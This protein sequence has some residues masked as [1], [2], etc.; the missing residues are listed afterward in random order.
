MFILSL[1]YQMLDEEHTVFYMF[2][3]A[4][5]VLTGLTEQNGFVFCLKALELSFLAWHVKIT[6]KVWFIQPRPS[7]S[8]AFPLFSPIAPL[9]A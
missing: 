5:W 1:I 4:Q 9:T 6:K 3:D 2:S 7:Y 8:T